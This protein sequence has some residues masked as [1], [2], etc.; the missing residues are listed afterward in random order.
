MTG[1]QALCNPT[2]LARNHHVHTQ[3]ERI[4]G[5]P[6]KEEKSFPCCLCG[7]LSVE[8]AVKMRLILVRCTPVE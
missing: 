7:Q 6:W 1:Y 4:A 2:V 5:E 8:E 3:T